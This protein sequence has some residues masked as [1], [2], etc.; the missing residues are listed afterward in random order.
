MWKSCHAADVSGSGLVIVSAIFLAYGALSRRLQG[1]PITAPIVFVGTGLALGA[2]GLGWLRLDLDQHAVSVLAEAT[3]AVVLFTDASRIDM[4]LLRS[5]YSVPA[6]LLGIGLPLT[7]VAGAIAGVAVLTTLSL[8][9]AVVLAI[10]LAP[11]DA[12]LGQAVVTDR[13]LPSRIRQGLNVESGLNDGICVP[14]LTIALAI[15]ETDSGETSG[16]H[17]A[18]VVVDAI[19]WGVVGGLI[20]GVVAAY[21]VRV[22][23]R[24]SWM[25]DR[26]IQIVP[27]LAAAGAYGIADVRHGSGFIGAFTAGIVYG[28]ITGPDLDPAAFSEELGGL[29]NGLTLLVF[30]AVILGSAWSQIGV[31]EVVYAVLS[32]TVVR[33]IPV[34]IAMLGSE[35]RLPTVLFLGWFGPRGLA[36]IVFG[37]VVVEAAGLPHTSELVLAVTVTVALSVA[38][39]GLTAAPLARVYARWHAVSKAPMES[40]STPHQRWR[41]THRLSPQQELR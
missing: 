18:R 39:H 5:E 28:R 24:R 13:A 33:M 36:S 23:V 19:G 21:V 32:L 22:A 10:V 15:A 14:L 7:I 25:D 20:A 8:A 41:H 3:L 40:A 6:R 35:A 1:T 16:A 37:V 12:A 4:R 30:G 29:L 38:A 31:R 34:G 11:T 2:E 26:W 9:E 17:A 27:A